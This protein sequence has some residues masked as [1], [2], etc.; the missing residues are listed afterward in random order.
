MKKIEEF[1]LL[2]RSWLWSVLP[3]MR[4]SYLPDVLL[5]SAGVALL[6]GI[7]TIARSWLG[8]FT[9][10]VE[11]SHSLRALPTYA[12]YSVLRILA[13]YLLSFS[14][15]LVYGYIAAHNQKA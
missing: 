7:V 6:F 2:T 10:N 13:A 8:P 5:F 15:T 4:V 14:F 11:I 12:G 9:P 1:S 3:R